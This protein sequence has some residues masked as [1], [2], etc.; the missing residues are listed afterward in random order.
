M[1]NLNYILKSLRVS[2]SRYY[3]GLVS[4]FNTEEYVED[5]IEKINNYF[6]AHKLDSCVIGISGGLDSALVYYIMIEAMNSPNSPIKMIKPILMPIK[7]NG[8]TDQVAG[9]N[10]GVL[11]KGVVENDI[12]DLTYVHR[13]YINANNILVNSWTNGQLASL[14]RTPFL[15][16]K[17]AELQQSGYKSVVIGTTNLSEGGYI[18]F[19]GKG[20]DYMVDIQPIHDIYKSEVI[21]VAKYLEVPSEI[22]NRNPQGDVFDGRNDEEMIG[23]SYWFLELYMRLLYGKNKFDQHFDTVY[24]Y[25]QKMFNIGRTLSDEEIIYFNKCETEIKKIRKINKHKY[26]VGSPAVH[27]DVH[28]QWIKLE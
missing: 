5:K 2:Q 26:L 7:C 21:D 13:E 1:D 15:Y 9:T 17:A 19:Y 28:T 6:R 11:L 14:V 23:S 22:I 25:A 16:F 27:L 8:T 12:Y 20:S 4:T 18:G 3:K 24:D 10:Y